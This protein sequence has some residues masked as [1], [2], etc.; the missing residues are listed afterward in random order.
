MQSNSESAD[1]YIRGLEAEL[2]ELHK[3]RLSQLQSQRQRGNERVEEKPEP[4]TPTSAWRAA[5]RLAKVAIMRK[6]MNRVS[7]LHGF[8]NARF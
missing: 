7:D 3:R 2:A 6:S 8:E 4:L 1:E 5:E